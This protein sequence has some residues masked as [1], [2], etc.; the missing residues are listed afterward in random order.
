MGRNPRGQHRTNC[1]RSA[2][3]A[4]GPSFILREELNLVGIVLASGEPVIWCG[5]QRHRLGLP[6]VRNRLLGAQKRSRP[7]PRHRATNA[8]IRYAVGPLGMRRLGI[9]H[10]AGNRR[11]AASSRRLGHRPGRTFSVTPKPL[12]GGRIADRCLYAYATDDG[13]AAMRYMPVRVTC[14][15]TLKL[16]L[17]LPASAFLPVQPR[18]PGPG[19]CT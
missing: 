12:L 2:T 14:D 4:S 9:S 16:I 3:P 13:A 19:D 15:A 8:L 17:Q 1:R 11:A 5:F 10:A 7:G 18:T 6:P